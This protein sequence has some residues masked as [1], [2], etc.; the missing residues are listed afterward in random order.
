M[1]SPAATTPASRLVW[2]AIIT[3][4]AVLA[5]VATGLLSAAGGVPLPLAVIAGGGAFGG[6]TGLLLAVA[7]Y[8]AA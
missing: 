1:T 3:I 5:G 6:T 7:H 2:A 8:I 4:V